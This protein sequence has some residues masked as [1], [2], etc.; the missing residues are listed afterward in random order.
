MKYVTTLLINM[1]SHREL[2]EGR[3]VHATALLSELRQNYYSVYK[4][5]ARILDPKI[6]STRELPQDFF[7]KRRIFLHG[8]PTCVV[9]GSH[10]GSAFSRSRLLSS[11]ERPWPRCCSKTCT[12]KDPRRSERTASTNMKRYGATS[13]LGS[14]KIRKKI[15][16]TFIMRY[17]G[18]NCMHSNQVRA[19]VR[20]TNIKRYG[21]PT[22]MSS[23][24][25]RDKVTQTNIKRYGCKRAIQREDILAKSMATNLCRRGVAWPAQDPEVYLK[26]E[27]TNI[28]RYGCRNAR[29]SDQAKEQSRKTNLRR[30]GVEYSTQDPRVVEKIRQTNMDRYG[31][32]CVFQSDDVKRK[33]MATNR[34]RYGTDYHMQNSTQFAKNIHSGYRKKV[35]VQNGHLHNVQG[36]EDVAAVWLDARG[37]DIASSGTKGYRSFWYTKASGKRGRYHPDFIVRKR[38]TRELFVVEVKSPYTAG[39]TEGR[40][41]SKFVN[42]LN[43]YLG[44]ENSKMSYVLLL[45]NGT[46]VAAYPGKPNFTKLRKSSLL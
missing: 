23:L 35:I 32:P 25:V 9:C 36:Y 28:K 13:P 29:A 6:Y 42:M 5:Y 21:G 3:R 20:N 31:V 18:S 40:P 2:V 17:G 30:R 44:V 15:V 34:E 22:C 8:R 41:G 1:A 24:E 39:I 11:L 10:Q 14:K 38:S 46:D 33:S 12:Y 37:F 45:C 7:V 26:I 4:D 27:E 16:A 43:K 19:R